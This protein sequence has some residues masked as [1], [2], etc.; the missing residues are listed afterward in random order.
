MPKTDLNWQRRAIVA[1]AEYDVADHDILVLVDTSSPAD[2]SLVRSSGK[3]VPY[4]CSILAAAFAAVDQAGDI[5]ETI[6][7]VHK[8]SASD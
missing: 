5:A 1:S 7:T 2:E 8:P 3:Q 6:I 4:R